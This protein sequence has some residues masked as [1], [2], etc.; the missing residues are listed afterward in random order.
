MAL[1]R[2]AFPALAF[3]TFP[4]WPPLG[5]PAGFALDATIIHQRQEAGL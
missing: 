4:P 2:L 1:A 3:R 5:A